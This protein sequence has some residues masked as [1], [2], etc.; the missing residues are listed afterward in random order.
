MLMS[1]NQT[2]F[3][4]SA[5]DLEPL[6]AVLDFADS[7][8]GA[9]N[10][11][12]QTYAQLRLRPG[13][14]VLDVGCG[15]GRAVAELS[16]TGFDAV[17]VDIDARMLETATQRWPNRDFRC[18]GATALPFEDGVFR[19]YRADKILHELDDP[20]SAIDEARRVLMP[21][22]RIVLIGQDWHAYMIDSAYPSLT[23]RIVTA[24]AS[25][26]PSPSATRSFRNLLLDRGFTDVEVAGQ[27]AVLTDRG[28]L[29]ISTGFAAAALA[30]GAITP[31]ESQEWLAD[32]HERARSGRL[33]VALPLFVGSATRS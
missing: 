25:T 12:R 11:R 16:E 30:A 8:P 2:N 13:D 22:G 29:A 4:N 17:G 31:N 23:A 7:Q 19:G 28:A 24:R 27:A 3:S 18:A 5:A 21:Q 6:V 15:T 1:T 14:R 33:F 32:Q 20:G 9:E 10:L 26:V